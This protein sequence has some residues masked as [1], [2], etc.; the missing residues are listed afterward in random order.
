MLSLLIFTAVVIWAWFIHSSVQ[1]WILGFI[2]ALIL[3][4]GQA[5]SL[6][7]FARMIPQGRNAEFFGFYAISAKFAAIAGPLFFAVIT[8]ITGSC[9]NSIAAMAA[10]FLIGMMLLSKVDIEK[11]RL[12]AKNIR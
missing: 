2:I 8:D 5:I 10:F 3:G 4:G 1:F 9:R 6:A 12:R 11:G 7:L